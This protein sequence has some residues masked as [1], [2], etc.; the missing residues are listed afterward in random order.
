MKSLFQGIK[1]LWQEGGEKAK[2]RKRKKINNKPAGYSARLF[3]RFTFWLAFVFMFVFV[4]FNVLVDAESEEV[5]TTDAIEDFEIPD[6]E[7]MNYESVR[8]GNRFLENYY[9][10][11]VED[12][13][14]RRERLAPFLA[15]EL[16]Q[17][18]GLHVNDL[19][20]SSEVT[21]IE[22]IAFEEISDSRAILT[23]R[24]NATFTPSEEAVEENE[25]LEPEA[26]QQ[27]V[28]VPIAYEN[29]SYG[30]Y[31][32][33]QYTN[34]THDTQV[35]SGPT[36]ELDAYEGDTA[37][38]QDFLNTFF[39]SYAED[40]QGTLNYLTTADSDIQGLYGNMIFGEISRVDVQENQNG[41]TVAFADV[42]FIEPA[43]NVSFSSRYAL[44]LEQ[45][46]GQYSVS[47]LNKY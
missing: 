15:N 10:W 41:E 47:N 14:E 27:Y 2:S 11:D 16:D 1:R 18:G 42:T 34:Y 21:E 33:P 39:S 32:L 13:S 28:S 23:Y 7:A 44:E 26:F 29:D 30:V 46:N 35:E 3:G 12:T 9:N 45:Q 6:N 38:V 19:T 36:E 43:G 24:V 25:E 37:A 5:S 31:E 17:D 4:A 20:V 22:F 40:D 8:Y